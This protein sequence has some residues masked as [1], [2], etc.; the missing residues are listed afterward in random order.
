[1]T[2]FL[3][4]IRKKNSYFALTSR[5]LYFPDGCRV[6]AVDPFILRI[7]FSFI[8]LPIFVVMNMLNIL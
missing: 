6:V 3:R 7:W 8:T 2:E 5:V 1:M 4:K